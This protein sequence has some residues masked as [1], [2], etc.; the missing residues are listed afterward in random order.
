MKK[1]HS[2]RR[3]LFGSML[4][5]ALIPTVVCLAVMMHVTR[6]QMD[7]YTQ[8]EVASSLSV[9]QQDMA[10]ISDSLER[11]AKELTEDQL[12]CQAL[13]QRQ[14]HR[15]EVNS[16][17]HSAAEDARRF[18]VF[19][20]YSE[21]GISLYSTQ[22][23]TGT[24]LSPN[25][26]ILYQAARNPGRA[27]YYTSVD[28][29]PLLGAIKLK[30]PGGA[31]LGYLVMRI[32]E[33]GFLTLLG[34]KYSL[35][36]VL[37]MNHSF[38]PVFSSPLY[39]STSLV[40]AIRQHL[41]TGERFEEGD[42]YYS[43]AYH[44]PTG[45]YLMIRQPQII[46]NSTV[47]LLYT[48]GITCVLLSILMSIAVSLTLSRQLSRPLLRLQEAFDNVQQDNLETKLTVYSDDE[49]GT[50]TA[51]FNDMVMALKVNRQE[52]LTNQQELDHAQ[53]RMLQ[54]QLNPHFLC[55][56]LDTM[57]WI[58]K[59]NKVPQVAV[60]STDLADI[61]RFCISSEEFVP[62]YREIEILERYI[63]IQR[64]R[65]SDDF[66]FHVDIQEELYDC[67]ISKMILQP[68]VENAVVHGVRGMQG[69]VIRVT[70]EFAEGENFRIRVTDNGGGFPPEMI[71][72]PYN[73]D[74][75]RARGHLGLYNVDTILRIKYGEEYG[76]TLSNN[77]SGGA[78]VTVLLPIR[79]EEEETEC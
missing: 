45:L 75:G 79:Y 68:I 38:Q 51:R 31:R 67:L 39:L 61:L 17:L 43:A 50:L 18:A 62:L 72:R 46:T 32:D 30:S 36:G 7:S 8:T 65:L 15:Q 76:L 60:M 47:W 59:I 71:G 16:L 66:D 48:A 1:G 58:S 35:G 2:F 40:P 21:D 69:S 33:N 12:V 9:L 54:A 20:L 78:C 14:N 73:R 11:I 52:L 55:N 4:L 64:I 74:K 57:K 70:G 22:E 26:G 37:V 53:I 27:V 63:E 41:L 24:D 77:E 19:D 6:I 23:G 5:A 25:W 49:L 28:D 42:F 56:T 44:E 29:A 3:R 34:S 13:I 10:L